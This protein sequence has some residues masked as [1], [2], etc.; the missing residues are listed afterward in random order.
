MVNPV[1]PVTPASL[2][3]F[4]VGHVTS[5]LHPVGT[6]PVMGPAWKTP[7]SDGRVKGD[8]F[9]V[10]GE[11]PVLWGQWRDNFV[12]AAAAAQV[13]DGRIFHGHVEDSRDRFLGNRFDEF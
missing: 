13:H 11:F 5:P 2:L 9:A 7:V 8:A 6:D 12:S 10:E 4:P 1:F 3:N